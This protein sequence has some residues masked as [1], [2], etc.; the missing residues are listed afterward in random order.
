MRRMKNRRGSTMI[1]VGLSLVALV[2]IMAFAVDFGRMY[3]FRAQVHVS[4]DAAALAGAE[5]LMRG[6][7]G[8]A[9]DTAVAYGRLNRVENAIPTITTGDIVPGRWQGGAFTAGTWSAASNAVRATSRYT[10]SYRFGRIFGLNTRLRSAT[11]IAAVGYASGTECVRPM[12]VP[13]QSLLDVLFPP[14]GSQSLS[15]HPSLDTTDVRRLAQLTL[16]N[17]ITLAGKGNGPLG[18]GTF[19]GVRLPPVQ[20]ADGATGT[21]WNNSGNNWEYGLGATCGDLAARIQ[22][23]GGR[24]TIGIGDQLAEDNGVTTSAQSTG[25]E[26]L[27]DNY[28]GGT[29]PANPGNNKTFS[30]INPVPVKVAISST[31]TG[32]TFLVKY[33]GIFAV[34]GFTKNT[35]IRGYF[36]SIAST[37]TFSLTPSPIKKIAL[38]Q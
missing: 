1:L 18:S 35:G 20:Y 38:V 7:Y 36:S 12:V 9:A 23:Y 33:I 19:G 2:G 13:Y 14:A 30:C 15:T 26:D 22:S 29:D 4:A 5:R 10:A 25:V 3:L 31:L 24:T 16:A 34:T 32:S 11:S 6:Q 17:E 8:V 28:G 27:C 21:P 37:G